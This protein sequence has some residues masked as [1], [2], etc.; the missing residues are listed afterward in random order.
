[1]D[2]ASDLL[3]VL[4]KEKEQSATKS[5][6]DNYE[7]AERV[8]TTVSLYAV[9]ERHLKAKNNLEYVDR[10]SYT[11]WFAETTKRFESL[12]GNA[13]AVG[14]SKCHSHLLWQTR[15]KDE[16]VTALKKNPK[17][18]WRKIEQEINHWCSNSTIQRWITS[19]DG[20][21]TYAK[22]I[23]PL[24]SKSQQKKHLDFAMHL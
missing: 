17:S 4:P 19:K 16:I 23:I 3:L 22:R 24:L 9:N 20:Y 21:K 15:I 6:I 2:E 7:L 18:S 10:K 1:M 5:V 12:D 14:E 13:K 8:F 11:T